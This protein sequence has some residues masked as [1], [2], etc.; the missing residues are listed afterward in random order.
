MLKCILPG[1]ATVLLQVLSRGNPQDHVRLL[2][3]V[4]GYFKDAAQFGAWKI[5]TVS[6]VSLPIALRT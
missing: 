2:F 3:G 4:R 5:I 6:A 1:I